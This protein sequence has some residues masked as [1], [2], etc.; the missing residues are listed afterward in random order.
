MTGHVT[1][2]YEAR[3]GLLDL[4]RSTLNLPSSRADFSGRVAA[5]TAPAAQA[6]QELQVHLETRDLADILPALGENPA[7]FPAKLANGRAIFDGTVTGN[8]S[9]PQIAGHVDVTRFSFE[10]RIFDSLRADAKASPAGLEGR[11]AVIT[12][13]ALRAEFQGSL[14]LHQWKIEDSSNI[15]GNGTIRNADLAAV[16]TVLA[17]QATPV[18][19]T[20]TGSAQFSGTMGSP[21]LVGDLDVTKGVFQEQPFDQLTAHVNYHG[22]TIEVTQGQIAA[23][24][25]RV[26]VSG[27]F[28]HSPGRLDEGRVRFRVA[29]N[30]MPLEQIQ[31]VQ[32]V[33]SGAKGT[34]QLSADGD[35]DLATARNGTM[36][37]RIANLNADLA[38]RGL[39]LDGQ[40]L[41]DAHL[42]AKS[43]NAV[44]HAQLE[45]NFANSAIKG[46]GQWRLE[47]NYPGNATVTFSRLD[48]ARLR[49]WISPDQTSADN[50]TGF[51]E[52]E[53][54]MEGPALQADA[55]KSELRVAAFEISAAAPVNN[56]N[57]A[58]PAETFTLKNSGPI[59]AGMVNNVVTIDSA[60][61]VG[62][63]TDLSIA[64]KV[65]LQ[66]KSPLDLRVNGRL[67]WPSCRS[68]TM[69][70]SRP[71]Q[72]SR[73]PRFG[74][75]W[76]RLRW[77]G[78]CNSRMRRSA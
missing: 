54:R 73:K 34:A 48:F 45:S 60:R 5:G 70:L 65:L 52:G 13:G 17:A 55:I 49:G 8:L 69:T 14:S 72:W 56:G 51:A 37:F 35:I 67:D 2:V 26:E 29:S 7:E 22:H 47:G 21:A 78:G 62:R 33:R 20:M 10:D 44:L 43:Q 30:P 71:E 24:A 23:G 32:E 40:A 4:G 61:F 46:E 42:T 57:P 1:A 66:Q 58:S 15:A 77:Q 63:S 38:A 16:V 6:A 39:E 41:G 25:S 3:S 31:A 19:G 59:V 12:Q 18:T 64:G 28:D 76:I 74:V 53:L 11:N 75:R 68:S 27:T 50:L 36:V 9:Q